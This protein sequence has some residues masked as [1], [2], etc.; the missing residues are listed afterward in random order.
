MAFKMKKLLVVLLVSLGLQTQAQINY[1]DSVSYTVVQGTQTLTTMGDAST[2]IN[3][4]DSIVWSW[5]ACNATMCYSG[6]GDTVSFQNILP[7]DTIKLCYYASIY[8]M[9]YTYTCSYCDSLVYDGNSYSWVLLN[10]SNPTTTRNIGFN[11][12]E[13]NKAYDLLGRELK[14]IPTGTMY[15]RNNRL[16]R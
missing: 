6:Y 5:Q 14:Y 1:C 13:D 12:I 10:T 2:F 16:Y 7:T 15:I 3:M 4:V 11:Y 8:L 9:G